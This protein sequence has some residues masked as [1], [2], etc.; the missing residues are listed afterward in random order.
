MRRAHNRKFYPEHEAF[1][2]ENAHGRLKKE[3]L[4]LFNSHFGTTFKLNQLDCFM[5]NHHITN[6]INARFHSGRY[7]NNSGRFKKG[8]HFS[9]ATEFKKGQRP[10]NHK[11][12]GSERIDR[13]GYVLVKVAE[14]NKWRSKH[15]VLWEVIHGPIPKK[16]I[17]AFR[18]RNKLNVDPSNLILLT[19]QEHLEMNRNHLYS[20]DPELIET[21]LL[22]AKLKTKTSS[23]RRTHEQQTR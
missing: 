13:D 19:M 7:A 5:N 8:T 21:G 20:D 12:V 1:V 3:L 23:L 4:L 6:G 15:K 18:D 16:H 11:P 17:L 22:L 14:P 10:I 2:R 9:P